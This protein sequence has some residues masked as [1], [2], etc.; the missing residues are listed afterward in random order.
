MKALLVNSLLLIWLFG[1]IAVFAQETTVPPVSNKNDAHQL[2][3][4]TGYGSNLIYY[5]TS[6]SEN[7]P[8]FSGELIYAWEGGLWAGAGFF[9]LPGEQPFVSFVDL[10]AGYSYVFNKVFDAGLA[11]SQYHSSQ[12]FDTTLLQNFTFL[13]ANLG[14][15]LKFLFTKITPGWLIANE[16]NF[17]LLW[18]NSYFLKT[19]ELGPKGSYF[20]FNPAVSFMFGSYAYLSYFYYRY[21]GGGVGGGG[22]GPGQG[23]PGMPLIEEREDFRLLDMQFSI[24]VAFYSGRISLEA[25]PAY[26]INFIE[27]EN[28]NTSKR[29]FFTLGVYYKIF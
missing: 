22:Q 3:A 1:H 12:S 17:Y 29:F 15:D 6:I 20:S 9:H 14:V 11:I 2:F 21:G 4:G 26:F 16:S 13:S 19:P 5:G 8:Y 24:P 23:G 7:Q 10:S 25:E 18:D 27:D 28:G